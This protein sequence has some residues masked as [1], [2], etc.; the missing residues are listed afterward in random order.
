MRGI[1][2]VMNT[3]EAVVKIK[4]KKNIFRLFFTTA[5]T[6]FKFMAMI[7]LVFI[8]QSSVQTHD[9]QVFTII[10]NLDRKKTSNPT[11]NTYLQIIENLKTHYKGWQDLKS[12]NSQFLREPFITP[13]KGIVWS[14]LQNTQ[15]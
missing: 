12:S 6:L 1:F 3:T 4:P 10:K 13:F 8:Y 9:I 11:K 2:T 15:R 5:N 14:F 7:I